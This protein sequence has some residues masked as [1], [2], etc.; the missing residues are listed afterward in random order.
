MNKKDAIT[1]LKENQP[2]PDDGEELDAIIEVFGE[3][4]EYFLENPD[5]EC[6]PLFLNCFG[7]GNG[8][9]GY[10]LIEDVMVKHDRD[11]VIP[12]LKT[13]LQSE[14]ASV[15]YWCAQIAERYDSEELI[16]GLFNVYEKGDYDAKCASLTTLT[17]IKKKKV[18]DF[19]KKV[20]DT[21]AD[22]DLLEIA[23]D[24]VNG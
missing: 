13:A 12:H 23:E 4:Q 14:S 24:I 21:E 10:Q 7:Q 3:V 20:I 17:V 16:D 19:V 22:E 2:L 15:R 18:I 5:P 8:N 11:I 9:G 1:F 6:V